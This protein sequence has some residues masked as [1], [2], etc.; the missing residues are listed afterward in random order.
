MHI[1]CELFLRLAKV[2]MLHIPYKGSGPALVDVI[3]GQVPVMCDSMTSALPHIRSGKLR[4]L[5]VTSVTR[6]PLLPSTPTLAEAGVE[7][8]EMI[9]WYGVFAPAGTPPH[10]VAQLNADINKV[11][12]LPEVKERFAL[13]GAEAVPATS[14]QFASQVRSDMAKWGKLI[15]EMGITVD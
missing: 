7:N 13:I 6:S 15:K 9:P 10:I 3:G 2:D 5:G 14:E 4:A 1:S 11:L 12:A 8:Y